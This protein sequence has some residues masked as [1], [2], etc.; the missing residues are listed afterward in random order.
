MLIENVFTLCYPNRR[1]YDNPLRKRCEDM[2]L[3]LMIVDDSEDFRLAL[4]AALSDA[5][6]IVQCCNGRQ[7]LDTA[8]QV[9]PDVMILD[10]MLTEVDG[11]TLL[12]E[13]RRAGL[14]PIVLAV[15]RFFNGYIMESAQ[16]LGIGYLI[17]KPCS[18]AAV[19]QRVRDLC[20]RLNSGPVVPINPADYVT[21]QLKSLMFVPKHKGFEYLKEAVLLMCRQPDISITKELYPKVGAPSGSSPSQVER[22]IRSAIGVAWSQG[23]APAWE[24]FFPPE[25]DGTSS[26]PSNGHVIARLAKDLQEKLA[27]EDEKRKNNV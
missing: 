1:D 18:P 17:R 23:G 10:L 15:T 27:G 13:I 24:R 4:E 19:S 7:A 11:V 21:E 26:K 2:A 8:P 6:R 16:E 22:S 14:H 9:R 25:A 20:R 12:H 3:T 5:F